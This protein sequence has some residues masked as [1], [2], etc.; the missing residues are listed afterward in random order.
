MEKNPAA[1][2][3]FNLSLAGEVVGFGLDVYGRLL[4]GKS[5]RE[6]HGPVLERVRNLTQDCYNMPIVET[7]EVRPCGSKERMVWIGNHPRYETQWAVIQSM[8][9]L[10]TNAAAIGKKELLTNP[11]YLPPFLGWPVKWAGLGLF[12]SRKDHAQAVDTLQEATKTLFLPD[13]GVIVLTDKHRPTQEAIADDRKKFSEK[14][15][16]EGVDEWLQHTCFPSSTGLM[17]ILD[18]VNEI[19][20]VDFSSFLDPDGTLHIHKEEIPAATLLNGENSNREKNL[21]AWLLQ[22]YRW[23]NAW[24]DDL[25]NQC[26]KNEKRD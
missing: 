25:Q 7:G 4:T 18:A 3:Q 6:I 13:T 2:L 21:R 24:M 12:V 17:Q 10:A 8:T 22:R 15:P 11:V 26:G 1:D 23:K 19:R 5:C 9:Q 20:V 16:Q 14:Y